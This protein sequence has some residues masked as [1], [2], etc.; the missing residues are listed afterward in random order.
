MNFQA[1]RTEFTDYPL[2]SIK[3][4][5]LRFPNF[6]RNNLLRWQEKGYL[7]K[8][9]NGWYAF[10]TTTAGGDALF[11]VSNQIY[12]PSY[13]SM[14]SALSAYGFIPEGVFQTTAVST[15]K[16]KR[17][18]TPLGVFS[19]QHLKPALFFGQRV[20]GYGRHFFKTASPEKAILDFLYL[21]PEL[22]TAAHVEGLR[23]NLPEVRRSVTVPIFQQYADAF[24][25]KALEK[26]AS[27]F[28]QFIENE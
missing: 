17:F 16:T 20:Q 18:Q 19:Y 11:F 8:I 3:D 14:E 5:E 2:F 28:L 1:F 10:S 4:I 24:Q 23:F 25:S 15:L 21:R 27:L 9:R 12:Q 7:L 6:D 26:R 22:N 13:I